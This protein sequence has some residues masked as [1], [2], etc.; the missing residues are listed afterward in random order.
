MP[1]TDTC[2]FVRLLEII[3][4]ELLDGLMDS[5]DD[6]IQFEIRLENDGVMAASEGSIQ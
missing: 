3:N 4:S 2:S 5:P 6:K 1:V